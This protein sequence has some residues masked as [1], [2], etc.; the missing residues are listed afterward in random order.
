VWSTLGSLRIEFPS[1]KAAVTGSE[2][3]FKHYV[4]WVASLQSPLARGGSPSELLALLHKSE[5]SDDGRL[6]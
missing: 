6:P 1:L 4:R 2:C 3:F 5:T